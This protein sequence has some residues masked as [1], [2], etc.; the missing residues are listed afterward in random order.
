MSR[1][2]KIFPWLITIL[3]LAAAFFF[4]SANNDRD[5]ELAKLRPQAEEISQLKTE[6]AELKK[7]ESQSGELAQ[8][9]KENTEL[10]KLRNEV[11]KLRDDGKQLARQLQNAQAEAKAAQARVEAA[12]AAQDGQVR[13]ASNLQNQIETWRQYQ[14]ALANQRM[15]PTQD[16]QVEQQNRCI[17]IREQLAAAKMQWALENKKTDPAI[18]TASDIAVYFKD[19][20][21]PKC[22]A[23]GAYSLNSLAAHP[24]CS[25]LG[26][27]LPQQ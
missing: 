3:A 13:A 4:Y 19:G 11:R 6:N 1:F 5:S 25:I 27:Q 17:N 20:V 8:L 21:V 12:S 24:T 7:L 26:H 22:P 2:L 10:L 9:K 15:P 18:P 23:G 16:P 14:N